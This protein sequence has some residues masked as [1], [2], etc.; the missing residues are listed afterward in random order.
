MTNIAGQVRDE[1]QDLRCPKCN[2]VMEKV[3][4][5]GMTVDRCV[6]C[7][8]LWFDAREKEHL[9]EAEGAEALDTGRPG[10]APAPA[11]PAPG[12][13]IQCPVCHTQMIQ[14]TDHDQPHIKYESCTVC[15]GVF[16]DAGEFRDYKELTLTESVKRLFPHRGS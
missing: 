13:K 1:A 14:M 5:G 15:H 7:K 8:G 12:G 4:F 10:S 9:K 3:A 6:S 11:A 2:A 16:F